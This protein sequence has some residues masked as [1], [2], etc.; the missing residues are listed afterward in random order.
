MFEARKCTGKKESNRD[1]K[2]D[3]YSLCAKTRREELQ[4]LKQGS[5]KNDEIDAHRKTYQ[6][7]RLWKDEIQ[8]G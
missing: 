7:T 8:R 6:S 5:H 3:N 4:G 1:N 2:K